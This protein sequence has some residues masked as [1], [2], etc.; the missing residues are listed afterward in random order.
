MK[1]VKH[2]DNLRLLLLSATPMY[3]SYK[4]IVWLLNLMNRNDHRSEIDVK[5]IFDK[6]KLHELCL[7]I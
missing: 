3:N 7:I 5:D 2:I 6:E 4:E 1:L